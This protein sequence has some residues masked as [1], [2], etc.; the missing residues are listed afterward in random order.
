MTDL[1]VTSLA[2][3]LTRVATMQWADSE[4]KFPLDF[5]PLMLS[6]NHHA[7]Q[8]DPGA[9]ALIPLFA[10]YQWYA[11]N[12]AYLLAKLDSVPE[13]DGTLLDNTLVLAITEIQHPEDHAQNNMPFILGG[14]AQGKIRSGRWLQ[15]PSQSHNTLLVSLLNIFGGDDMAFGHPDFN[16]GA[17]A[18]LS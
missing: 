1:L 10:I 18:G 7:Y 5:A 9:P 4:A 2:C 17:L 6:D 12:L 15:V 16:A 11:S 13:G 14:K 3:D 8:H